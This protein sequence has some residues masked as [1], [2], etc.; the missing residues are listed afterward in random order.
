MKRTNKHLGTCQ[1]KIYKEHDLMLLT[2]GHSLNHNGE[3][4]CE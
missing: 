1:L 2:I 3:D 4:C